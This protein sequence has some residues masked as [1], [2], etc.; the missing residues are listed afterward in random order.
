MAS[1]AATLIIFGS[2]AGGANGALTFTI[3]NFTSDNLTIII[4][5][6]SAVLEATGSTPT[7]SDIFIYPTVGSQNDWI[8]SIDHNAG[9]A[10]QI[11][12]ATVNPGV[13]AMFDNNSAVGDIVR[14]TFTS[15]LVAGDPVTSDI[16]LSWTG[17]NIF[18]PTAVDSLTLAWGTDDIGSVWPW[19]DVQSSTTT[20]VPEP[21]AALLLGI[22]ALGLV[23]RRKKTT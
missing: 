22:G 17:T 4:P 18:D 5:T 3:D 11:G 21:T 10:G 2:L 23:A 8:L 13:F 19:G 7:S 20:V 14:A 1:L 9:G 12:N 16:T 6:S 15:P